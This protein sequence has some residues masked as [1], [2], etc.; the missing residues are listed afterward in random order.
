MTGKECEQTSSVICKICKIPPHVLAS[1]VL[2]WVN[3]L[4]PDPNPFLNMHQTT[5]SMDFITNFAVQCI[6]YVSSEVG[7]QLACDV[8]V[9]IVVQEV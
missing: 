9:A 6:L 3:D 1:L 7:Y 8:F 4:S 2:V 5:F